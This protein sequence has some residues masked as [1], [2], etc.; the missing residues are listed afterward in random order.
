MR[1]GVDLC[2]LE[3]AYTGG[4]SSFSLGLVRGL[5][6]VCAPGD[7][8]VL[9]VVPR[10]EAYLRK[11]FSS[12]DV[13]F[14][15]LPLGE[16]SWRIDALTIL[17]SWL[18]GNFKLRYWYDQLFRAAVMR[19]IDGSA[20]VV[21]A[22]MML[23][24]FFAAR[25]P[26]LVSM[27]DIQQEY[28]PEFFTLRQRIARWAPYR[29]T[30]WRAARIQ[31]SSRYIAECLREKFTFIDPAKIVVIPESVDRD[32][33]SA[34]ARSEP[35]PELAAHSGPFVFYPA[36]IWPHKNHRLLVDAL[37]R[38]REETGKEIACVLTGRDYG[39][40]HRIQKKIGALGL[41]Q[42][43]YLGQVDFVRLLWLYQ[44]C[45]AVL[46][47]GMHESSSLPVREGA[48]F[49][50]VLIALDIP[51]N[52][53]TSE[54][55]QIVLVNDSASL[56]RTLTALSD[57]GVVEAGRKNA[58]LVACFDGKTIA[59]EYYRVLRAMV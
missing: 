32:R 36:Q 11:E 58:E 17:V 34:T 26:A 1:I 37:A 40:W 31:A 39:D 16:T 25:R 56:A 21:L 57:P 53:E 4:L 12:R 52:R 6:A 14:V 33:F 7:R 47:L 20:D 22:P 45:T 42:V 27:H 3:P 19:R 8:L 28:H 49:G 44:N 51:P 38:Y 50:K 5:R 10:N 15:S 54:H 24:R 13:E 2:Y 59:G 35:P 41:R 46:A 48:V 23:L 43:Y 29:L 9:F 18:L 30:G 55:L